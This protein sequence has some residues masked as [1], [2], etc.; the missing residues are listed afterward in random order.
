[1]ANLENKQKELVQKLINLYIEI[2]GLKEDVKQIKGDAED[3]LVKGDIQMADKVAK[4]FVA[5]KFE[6]Q[7]EKWAEFEDSYVTLVG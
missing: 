4:I 3:Y 7:Q 1:M 6:D 5:D 2:E